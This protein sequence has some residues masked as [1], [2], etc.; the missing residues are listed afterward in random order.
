MKASTASIYEKEAIAILEALKRWKH[1]F[2]SS[3]LVIR[4]DQQSL[5]YI[6]D[7]RLVEGIQQKL[8]IKLL[9]FNY[10]VEYKKGRTNKAADALS[11]ATHSTELLAITAVVP[12]WMEQ[13]SKTYEQDHKC[14]DLMTKL[15]IDIQEIPN[16]PYKIALSD[17]RAG[18]TLVITLISS[19]NW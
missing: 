10:K 5:R 4:T 14:M 6:Q 3:S 11:R 18:C 16:L 12:L 17:T 9:G 1:Y 7:Q 15:S 19:K 8:L 13:M 2:A